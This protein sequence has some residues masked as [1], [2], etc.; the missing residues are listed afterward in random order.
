MNNKLSNI[1]TIL[2][3]AKGVK[4]KTTCSRV[5]QFVN[6][7]LKMTNKTFSPHGAEDLNIFVVTTKEEKKIIDNLTDDEEE[8]LCKNGAEDLKISVVTT[9]EKKEIIDNL[10]EEE[11]E[12]LCK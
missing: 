6:G 9:K 3:F 1:R 10:T 7:K 8:E 2:D 4:P 12:E 5:F 11:K